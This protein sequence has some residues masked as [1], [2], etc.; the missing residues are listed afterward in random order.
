M[1]GVKKNFFEMAC[2][3]LLF[4]VL[5]FI[6]CQNQNQA[7]QNDTEMAK[8]AHLSEL[9]KQKVATAKQLGM[10]LWTKEVENYIATINAKNLDYNAISVKD[11]EIT[12]YDN[13]TSFSCPVRSDK[14]CEMHKADDGNSFVVLPKEGE[15]LTFTFVYYKDDEGKVK[16]KQPEGDYSFVHF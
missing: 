3:V 6:G 7:M 13:R 5:L 16:V 10:K 15:K 4:G 2:V 11:L 14:I 12:S 8:Y 1:E 9:D